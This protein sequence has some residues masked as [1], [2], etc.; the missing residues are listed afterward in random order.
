MENTENQALPSVRGQIASRMQTRY[1][2]RQFG[3]EAGADGADGAEGLEQAILDALTEDESRINEMSERQKVYDENT[4]KLTNLFNNSPRAAVFLNTLAVTGDAAAAIRKAYGAEAYSAFNEGSASGVIA[5]IEAEDAKLRAENEQFEQEKEAN[6]KQSFEELQAFAQEKGLNEDETVQV[7]M[8]FHAIL[9][10]ALNG[11]YSRDLF[12]MGWKADH[13]DDDLAS[14]RREGEVTGRN[15]KIQE[16][17]RKRQESAA[18]PP[19]LSGQGVRSEE[20]RPAP[21]NDNPWM[22]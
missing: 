17:A 9:E 19:Q 10:D 1:P 8:R 2:D 20:S 22:L 12:E 13:Y 3:G 5:Q 6:L 14:A 16:M 11:K 7:F 18:M 15:A 4:E 21:K